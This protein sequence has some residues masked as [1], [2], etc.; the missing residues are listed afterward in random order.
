MG[1]RLAGGPE[2]SLFAR[3]IA[4]RRLVI[5]PVGGQRRVWAGRVS[6]LDALLDADRRFAEA[7]RERGVDGWVAWFAP[8]GCML[9]PAGGA[10]R[11]RRGDP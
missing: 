11:G 8:D 2:T 10:T 7:T 3:L 6:D 9:T 5:A 1:T 4:L